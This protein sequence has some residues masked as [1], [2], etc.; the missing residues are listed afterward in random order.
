MSSA[1]PRLGYHYYP[2]DRHFTQDDLRV[3]LPILK[4]LGAS[5]LT[6][7]GD[8]A[9]A[10]P[11]TFLRGLLDA[12]IEP[13]VRIPASI[14]RLR[15]SDIAPLLGIYARWGLRF[16]AVFDRP[17]LKANWDAAEWGRESLVERFIDQLLPILKVQHRAGLTPLFPPLEPGGD[18]WDTSFLELALRSLRRRGNRT[19][20][21]DL[22][23]GLYALVMGKPL[24]WGI[25]GPDRWAEAK[26]YL[27]PA[28]CQDQRGLHIADWYEDI[29]AGVLGTALPMISI[30]GGEKAGEHNSHSG[31]EADGQ[32]ETALAIAR[33][34]DS[35][36]INPLLRNFNFY[37]LATDPQHADRD[38]AWFTEPENP[39]RVVQLMRDYVKSLPR[40][41]ARPLEKP[42]PHYVLLPGPETQ[43]FERHWSSLGRI[44]ARSRPVVGFSPQEAKLAQRVTV[45]ATESLVSEDVLDMLRESGCTVQRLPRAVLGS[46][47]SQGDVALKNRR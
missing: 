17:N 20:L 39:R 34:L 2:D 40:R 35:E 5:W 24:D 19:I 28:G 38:W 7:Q 14:G 47:S 10:I 33:M 6:V 31:R 44:I 27:T 41:A 23:L 29:S 18:Y 12:G 21:H 30:A 26:P 22:H 9:R 8:P 15:E 16:V 36:H 42:L 25:G 13:I 1:N 43:G 32:A 46:F 11:E 45:A 37:L 3:W 4:S